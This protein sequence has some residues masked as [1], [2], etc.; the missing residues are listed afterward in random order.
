MK[1]V[2][3]KVIVCVHLEKNLNAQIFLNPEIGTDLNSK[4]KVYF[5]RIFVKFF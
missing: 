1:M 4:S 3:K 5:F 2:E